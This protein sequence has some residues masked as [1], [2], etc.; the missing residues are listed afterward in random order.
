MILDN[1]F[2]KKLKSSFDLNE[3]EVKV[4]AALLSKGIATA[5]ELS[6][7]SDV[8]RSRSY[9]V[10]ETL[11]KRGFVILKVGKPI[12]YIAI[13]PKEI[14]SRLKKSIEIDAETKIKTIDKLSGA[15]FFE[16]ISSLYKNGIEHIDPTMISGSIQGR[17]NLYNQMES[18]IKKSKKSIVIATT[19]KG[20]ARKN[21][22]FAKTLSSRAKKGVDIN[23]F[24]P[25]KS[26]ENYFED[27]ANVTESKDLNARFILI[28]N[29]EVLFMLTDE[30]AHEKVDTGIWVKSPF[31][32]NAMSNLVKSL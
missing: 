20:I 6:D 14:I 22:F 9:D 19:A 21:D 30:K 31:F 12:K 27:F 3:Y 1:E 28:D 8:P 15:D 29:K 13:E 18:M 4:W 32:V 7:I 23:I 16:E 2:L 10:L 11:E 17:K 24:T 5:G 26:K 25:N